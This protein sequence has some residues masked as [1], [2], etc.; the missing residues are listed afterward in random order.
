M[1][2]ALNATPLRTAWQRRPD[3]WVLAVLLAALGW[4]GWREYDFRCAVR[5]AGAAGLSFRESVSPLAIIREDW[6]CAFQ[7][8]TWIGRRRELAFPEG[9]DLASFRDLI[10]RLRPTDLD[11]AYCRH[12]EVLEEIKGLKKL[13]LSNSAV[14]QSKPGYRGSVSSALVCLLQDALI[15]FE[16]PPQ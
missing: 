4:V 9:S 12:E 6:S 3:V 15:I 10:L 8:S 11:V 1:P 5:E 13:R 14:L 7:K 2:D 16:I